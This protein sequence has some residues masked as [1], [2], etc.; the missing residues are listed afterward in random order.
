MSKRLHELA[1]IVLDRVYT[2]GYQ[3]RVEVDAQCKAEDDLLA[4]ERQLV[5]MTA[6]RD[7][8]IA[9]RDRLSADRFMLAAEVEALRK[10]V[11]AG[12]KSLQILA[13]DRDHWR[14]SRQQAIEAGELM[15]AEIETLRGQ[16]AD[17]K[18][19]ASDEFAERQVLQHEASDDN[20]ELERLRLEVVKLRTLN[21]AL[22]ESSKRLRAFVV[23]V[24]N[25]DDAASWYDL[26][27]ALNE[28]DAATANP[29]PA[30]EPEDGE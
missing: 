13:K 2:Y 5:D 20:A 26:E 18:R 1:E 15:Q 25:A 10:E 7:K 12:D 11:D 8:I 29:A 14:E 22:L 21:D 27:T 17:A 6:E 3:Q 28:L 19:E 9:E 4:A 30:S 23:K 24:R 16:L